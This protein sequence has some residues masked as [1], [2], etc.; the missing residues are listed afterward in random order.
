[1]RTS[2][3]RSVADSLSAI[4]V[5]LQGERVLRDGDRVAVIGGGPAGS[6]FS[7]FLLKLAESVDLDLAVDIYEPRSFSGCG[8]AGCNHC[9]GIVSESLVQ[10]L[11]AEGINLPPEVVQRGIESYVVHMDAGSV[12]IA[13]PR[14]GG[15]M[16]WDSFDDYLQ[17]MAIERG[18]SVVRKLV[19]GVEWHAGLPHLRD[20]DGGREAYDLV[21]VASGVNSNFLGLIEDLP[22]RASPPKTTR[23]YICE[24]RSTRE[25]IQRVLGNSMHVFLV[26]IPRLEFAALIPKGEFVTL[27][28]LG[29]HIDQDLI[30]R[31]L[32]TPEVRGCFP[33]ETTPSVC[34]CSPLINVRGMR[35]P[36]A[37]RLVMNPAVQGRHRGRLPHGQGG[38]GHGGV[39]GRLG[40]RLPQALSA[41]LP[42][43]LP[44]QRD[45]QAP[46]RIHRRVQGVGGLAARRVPDDRA[47][48]SRHRR[49]PAHE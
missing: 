14:H 26:A 40:G 19:S 1:M 15:E 35:Q 39:P 20:A 2:S 49:I 29:E 36:F 16:P 6:F 45:R 10:I 37:D 41:R 7:Y 4:H 43:D 17:G 34:T 23:T 13:R 12:R 18:A 27:C 30:H 3:R 42:T 11:A 32:R 28:M 9:G 22:E 47:R 46:V 21:A 33:V 44:R 8:P 24:F 25:E 38:G 5:D 48:A 31:F